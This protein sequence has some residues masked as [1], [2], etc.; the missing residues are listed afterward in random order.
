MWHAARR[1][2]LGIGR[3]Q[4]G[5]LMAIAGL[6]GVVRGHKTVTTQ[7]DGGVRFSV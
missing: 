4:V 2:G 1:A 6:S 7:R 3:D 5:R